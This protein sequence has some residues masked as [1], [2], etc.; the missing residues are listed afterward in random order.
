RWRSAA[1]PTRRAP[2]WRPAAPAT[3][4]ATA[5]RP[6]AAWGRR[7]GAVRDRRREPLGR[8]GALLSADD[9]GSFE[10]ADLLGREAALAQ[11]LVGML[12]ALGGAALDAFLGAREARRGGRLREARDVDIGA[13]RLGVRMLRGLGH[14]EHGREADVAALHD[15]APF[16]A[17]LGAEDAFQPALE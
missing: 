1:A 14:G 11:H 10:F 7:A 12:A 5:R 15:G 13:A 6:H 17:R 4:A 16:V 9:S 8:Y 3:A 2:R